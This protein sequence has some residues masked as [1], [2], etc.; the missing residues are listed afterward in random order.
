MGGAH[1]HVLDL[2]YLGFGEV[3]LRVGVWEGAFGSVGRWRW[4]W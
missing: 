1:L 3:L 2:L 4:F